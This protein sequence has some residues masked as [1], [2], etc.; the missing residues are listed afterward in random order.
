MAKSSK[1][2][3]REKARSILIK[4]TKINLKDNKS[5][6]FLYR[7]ERYNLKMLVEIQ[8]NPSTTITTLELLAICIPNH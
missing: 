7:L 4:N 3:K 5:Q 6:K 2:N 8:I 1:M